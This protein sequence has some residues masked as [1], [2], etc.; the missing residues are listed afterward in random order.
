MIDSDILCP[1]SRAVLGGAHYD[2]SMSNDDEKGGG[3]A[4]VAELTL[5]VLKGLRS[6]MRA[7]FDG[8]RAD[9]QNTN[10]RLDQTNARLDQTNARLE[11]AIGRLDRLERR[12]TEGEIRVATELTAIAN[13]VAALTDLLAKKLDVRDQVA[14]HE[15]RLT[16][17]EVKLGIAS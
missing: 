1:T 2:A 17:V 12:Q 10:A 14:D 4:T 16:V 6:D 8:L 9:V 15:K 3:D 7:G 13:G 5:E 11:E